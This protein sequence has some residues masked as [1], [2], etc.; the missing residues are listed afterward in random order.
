MIHFFSVLAIDSG[1]EIVAVGIGEG[2]IQKDLDTITS[3]KNDI[4]R[5]TDSD[6]LD[7]VTSELSRLVDL[8]GMFNLYFCCCLFTKFPRIRPFFDKQNSGN[9]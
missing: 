3:D 5:L 8:A 1:T 9:S 4:V 6:E 7:K 2:V